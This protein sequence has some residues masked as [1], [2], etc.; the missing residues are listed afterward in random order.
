MHFSKRWNS[1]CIPSLWNAI[2]WI[3]PPQKRDEQYSATIKY[4]A[5]ETWMCK[6][7]M[8]PIPSLKF[9]WKSEWFVDPRILTWLTLNFHC[10]TKN[11]DTKTRISIRKRHS[12]PKKISSSGRRELL[13]LSRR[14]TKAATLTMWWKIAGEESNLRQLWHI[15]RKKRI[16]EMKTRQ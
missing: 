5:I 6:S 12:I 16:L 1:A 7:S 11:K 15:M 13:L 2:S 14:S 9:F 8:R 10:V 3:H 4:R